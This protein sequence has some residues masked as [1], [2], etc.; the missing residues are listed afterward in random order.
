MSHRFDC[1]G[2]LR[3]LTGYFVF[4]VIL[5]LAQGSEAQTVQA[6]QADLARAQSETAG[7][8]AY[9]GG[10]ACSQSERPPI[11]ASSRF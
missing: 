4:V 1:P 10:V 3:R 9:P 6:N 7:L 5:A 8:N 11:L 2:S